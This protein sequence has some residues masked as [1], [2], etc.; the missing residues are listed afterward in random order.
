MIVCRLLTSRYR[1]WQFSSL[2][3][4][5]PSPHPYRTSLRKLSYHS[6]LGSLFANG[7]CQCTCRTTNKYVFEDSAVWQDGGH[8]CHPLSISISQMEPQHPSKLEMITIPTNAMWVVSYQKVQSST[9]DM[10]T[11]T[12]SEVRVVPYSAGSIYHTSRWYS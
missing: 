1:Y 7:K 8:T 4:H 5:I 2:E 9:C 10:H 6:T 12:F 3:G 11:V